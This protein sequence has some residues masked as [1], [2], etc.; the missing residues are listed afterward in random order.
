MFLNLGLGGMSC[1][2]RQFLELL[3]MDG[4]VDPVPSSWGKAVLVQLLEQLQMEVLA[5]QR[6]GGCIWLGADGGMNRFLDHGRSR[7]FVVFV[8]ME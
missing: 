1:F 3:L 4:P 2:P 8:R 7:Y 5:V 6:L